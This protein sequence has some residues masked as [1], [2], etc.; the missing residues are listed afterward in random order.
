MPKGQTV[1]TRYYSEVIL[2]KKKKTQR[3][4]EKVEPQAS[5]EKQSFYKQNIF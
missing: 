1:T 3:N 2:K 4:P 5:T